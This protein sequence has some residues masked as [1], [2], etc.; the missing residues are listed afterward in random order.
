MSEQPPLALIT[1]GCRR[2]GAVIAAHLAQA[3]YSLALHGH[4]DAK[5][6]DNLRAILNETACEWHGFRADLSDA[7]APDILIKQ[8]IAHFGRAPDVLINNASRFEYDNVD[9]MDSDRLDKHM[10]INFRSPVLLTKAL[11]DNSINQQPVI[12]QILDQR[13]RN[14]NADQISYTLSKQALAETVKTLA[15]AYANRARINAIAPGFTLAPDS[16][17]DEHVDRIAATMPLGANNSPDDIAQAA[18]YLIKAQ[19]VTGQILYVDGGA[20]L[21][22]YARD[23]EFM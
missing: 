16:F 2:V 12:I 20:H 6:D 15:I 21:K 8:T 13:I 17:S 4:S 19:S 1:G 9:M 7:A 23:F 3:G 14:P 11:I 18:L 5:P 22:S 10:A